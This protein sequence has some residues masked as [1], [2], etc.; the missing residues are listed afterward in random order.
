MVHGTS[1]K[2]LQH[3]WIS[4]YALMGKELPKKTTRSFSLQLIWLDQPLIGSSQLCETIRRTNW[5]DRMTTLKLS[6]QA[7]QNSRNSLKEL[8]ETLTL[9]AML[10]ENYGDFDNMDQHWSWYL[11]FNKSYLIWTGMKMLILPNLKKSVTEQ[12]TTTSHD[13]SAESLDKNIKKR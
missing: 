2:L 1:Y 9:H 10:N 13:R 4:I 3:N 8:L 7:M 11:N 5:I 12:V 6:L